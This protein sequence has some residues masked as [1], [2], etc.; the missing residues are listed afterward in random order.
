M[1]LCKGINPSLN[2]DQAKQ[3]AFLICA[4]LEG[5]HVM[6]GNQTGTPKYLKDFDDVFI[7]QAK[8]LVM[9]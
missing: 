6:Y 9:R 7:E 8:V 4:L 1:E 3:K 2:E 5:L